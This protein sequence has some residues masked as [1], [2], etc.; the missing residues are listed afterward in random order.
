M[1]TVDNKRK[2]Q[3]LSIRTSV[4]ISGDAITR[5][6]TQ[7]VDFSDGGLFVEGKALAGLKIDTLVYVQAADV[8][9]DPPLVKA[10]IAW[11][12]RYGAGIEYIT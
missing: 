2:H 6:K 4:I 9:D 5:F 11:T 10:R 3:R 12:N 7:T 1:P 8:M